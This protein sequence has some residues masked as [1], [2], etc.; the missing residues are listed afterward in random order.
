MR[1][2]RQQ[3]E[4]QGAL[5]EADMRLAGRMTRNPSKW[6]TTLEICRITGRVSARD[7]V[8][9]LQAAGVKIAPAK[10]LRVNENGPRVYGWRVGE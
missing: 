10:L 1:T 2:K 9:K 3:A 6:F 8:R 5:T 4:H 7:V